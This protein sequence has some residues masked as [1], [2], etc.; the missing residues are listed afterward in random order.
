MNSSVSVK[1][2]DRQPLILC[3]LCLRKLQKALDFRLI[4]RYKQ[5]EGFLIH[6]QDTCSCNGEIPV[7]EVKRDGLD[8]DDMLYVADGLGQNLNSVPC[9][10]SNDI[11]LASALI[12]LLQS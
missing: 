12:D 7:F 4:P 6:L 9:L 5:L 11:A 2:A 1:D 10:F 8:L 3:P